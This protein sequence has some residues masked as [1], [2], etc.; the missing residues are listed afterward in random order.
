MRA[1]LPTLRGTLSNAAVATA[2]LII[3]LASC[4]LQAQTSLE[5]YRNKQIR[6]IV[7]HAAGNDYDLAARFLA[8]YLA[9][10]IPGEPTIIVQNMPAA[11]SIAAANFLY[12]QAPR[13]G[14]VLGSFSR[15]VPSQALMGQNNIEA[16]PRRFNWLGATSHPAR[17]CARWH[18]APIKTP[19][20][21]FTQEFIV[22][23]AGA[24]SSLSI[25]PSVFNH[26][27][28]TKF[29]IVQGYKGTT[30]TI[31]AMERGEVQG[32][33]MSYLQLRVYEQLIRD[34]KILFLFRAEESPITEAPGLPSIFDYAKTEEQRALMRFVFSSTELG[35]PYVLPPEVPQDRVAL[36]RK[37]FAAAVTD[38]DLI[39]EAG[40]MK[41]D[42]TYRPPDALERL[43]ARLY[44]SP[45]ELIETVKKLVPNMQ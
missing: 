44:E 35:R 13:D 43:L 11:A 26:V 34:G 10:H 23:G 17:V 24:T 7:G 28:G 4:G 18:T 45:P 30:D 19:A 22:A 42:M 39:S 2:S 36:M 40:R 33:C 41:L 5:F 3:P 8:R 32:A 9:K 38:P 21:V 25:L 6:M 12:N 15:N 31:L 37:A 16:D 14:T 29:C 20:D 27:L 1:P